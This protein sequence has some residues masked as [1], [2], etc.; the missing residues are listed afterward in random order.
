MTKTKQSIAGILLLGLFAS[1]PSNGLDESEADFAETLN[2]AL[3]VNKPN[4]LNCAIAGHVKSRKLNHSTCKDHYKKLYA[5]PTVKV[6]IAF[7]YL[8]FRPSPLVA[9]P[10]IVADFIDSM[11]QACTDPTRSQF[12]G[13]SRDPDH[14]N[15]F[16]KSV[17]GPE[18]K[19]HT[20]QVSIV[21]PVPADG[22]DND[23]DLQVSPE[24]KTRSATA[25]AAYLKALTT[26]DVVVYYGHAR[27]GG[28]PDFYPPILNAKKHPDYRLYRMNRPGLND[29]LDALR[30]S[31]H[32]PKVLGMI[33]CDSKLHFKEKLKAVAPDSARLLSNRVV[34]YD[35]DDQAL[36]VLLDGLMQHRCDQNF[37]KSMN[38][39]IEPIQIPGLSIPVRT[40]TKIPPYDFE[41]F[42]VKTPN[43]PPA[44]Y[45]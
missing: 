14:Q 41:G 36:A 1:S 11:T 23:D 21:S 39:K 13:F 37:V 24:Q 18:G 2:D 26:D 32:H 7:G 27:G 17:L 31:K 42:G 16:S 15:L 12:C 30:E 10:Q 20:F 40:E 34:G 35:E 19:K 38:R 25:R 6:S 3:S 33:A 8:D 44:P 22:N 29:V 28:G 4:A 9:T 45:R 43:V 5:N